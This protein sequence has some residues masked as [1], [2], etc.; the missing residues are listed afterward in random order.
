VGVATPP[1]LTN[2][3]EPKQKYKGSKMPLSIDDK[4]ALKAL[5]G[6]IKH[7]YIVSDSKA[8]SPNCTHC[9]ILDN[10]VESI[11]IRTEHQVRM[12]D[13]WS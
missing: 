8:Y 5:L 12:V 6:G 10:V 13:R 1:P 11:K 7:N 2:S 3:T 9:K 4:N